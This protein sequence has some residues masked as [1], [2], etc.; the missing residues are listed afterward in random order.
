MASGKIGVDVVGRACRLPGAAGV[1]DL[2]RLLVEER[3]AVSTI[4][5]D[6]WSL[7]AFHHPRRGEP[8]KSYTFRAGVLDRI[9][10]FDPA[11]FGLSKREA[12]Q[13]DPQQRLLLEVTWEAIADSGLRPSDLAGEPVGVFVGVSNLDSVNRRFFDPSSSDPYFMTGNTLSLV[14][15]RLSY[16]F[17][18]R[19]PSFSI[20]TA[21][22][23][24][25]VAL[26]EAVCALESGRIDTAIVAGVNV[27]LSPFPF[28]GFSAA[29][30]LSPEGLCRPF[31]ARGQG[32]VRAEGC[33]SLILQRRDAGRL[34]A[35]RRHARI[36]ASGSNSDGRT[37]GVA[38][39][40][41]E[42]QAALLGEVYARHDLDPNR[43]AFVEAHGTGTRAG[44]PAEARAIGEA[45]GRRR[46]R[47]LPIGSIK[48]NIGHLEPAAGLAGVLKA[49]LAL[50]HDLYPATLHFGEPNPDIAFGALNIEVAG[51][52]VALG[53][54]GTGRIAGVSSFGFGGTNAHVVIADPE[55]APGRQFVSGAALD[56]RPASRDVV[57]ATG[58]HGDEILVI[59]AFDGAALRALARSYAAIWPALAPEARRALAAETVH[60]RDLMP[61]RLV[62]RGRS[63]DEVS[64]RL[65][66]FA[67]DTKGAR[68]PGA[69]SD[70]ALSG[71]ARTAF[72]FNGN[73]AQWAG[74]GRIAL[75][76][77]ARFRASFEAVDRIFAPLAGWSLVEALAAE[78]LEARL[79]RTSIAQP[80]LL[81]VQIATVD[82]LGELGLEPDVVLGHSVGEV[83][84]AYAA[85]CLTLDQAVR[86][87]HARSS[88]QELSRGTGSMAAVQ[89]PAVEV[90]TFLAAGAYAGV[91]VAAV[92]GP[93]S[94]T[95]AGPTAA[96]ET[97]VADLKAKG[98]QAT[99]LK[100]DYPFHCALMDPAAAPLMV[101]LAGL[102]PGAGR[103]PLVSTV[104][105]GEIA[106]TD[107][108]ARYWWRNVR[109][110]VR[111]ADA[112]VA[113]SALGVRVFIEI[114]PHA[115]LR[116][117]VTDGLR[118]NKLESAVL[119]TFTRTDPPGD[120][121]VLAA[122][123]A[124]LA[125]GAL[126]DLE[127]AFGPR[128]VQ[129]AELPSYPWQRTHLQPAW[130]DEAID[131]GL[132]M[133]TPTE[134]AAGRHPHPL[135][136]VQSQNDQ[137]LWIG[138]LDAAA[139]PVLGDHKVHGRIVV[140]GAVFAELALAAGRRWLGA[141]T[142]ELRD[143]D[144]V[145]PLIVDG[146]TLRQVRV[147]ISGDSA[148]VEIASRTRFSG[149]TWQ[150]HAAGR[151][152]LVDGTK[153]IV[154]DD[155]VAAVAGARESAETE[156]DAAQIYA[157]AARLGLAYGP[158]FRL[159]KAVRRNGASALVVDLAPAAGQWG[160]GVALELEPTALD[161]A[162][163]GLLAVAAEH[164][165]SE[166]A[167]VPIRFQS[168]RI[169]TPGASPVRA[170]IAIRKAS[171]RSL[172][173]DITLDDAS[174]RPVVEVL[175]ARFRAV[176]ATAVDIARHM[177]SFS[178]ERVRIQR[179]V[180]EHVAPHPA[181]VAALPGAAG[182]RDGEARLLVEAAARRIALDAALSLA[183]ADGHIG[184]DALVRLATGND[185]VHAYLVS[186][187]D[188]AV[189]ADLAASPERGVW[190]VEPAADDALPALE[191]I[192]TTIMADHPAWGAEVA[193]TA[194]AA[195]AVCEIIEGRF[196]TA[197]APFSTATLDHLATHAP[198]ARGHVET[199]MA[200]VGPRID[201]WPA[202]RALRIV[203]LGA[204]GGE[205][206]RAIAARAVARRGRLVVV[207]ADGPASER[208]RAELDGIDVVEVMAV[209]EFTRQAGALAP[210]DLLVSANGL[211]TLDGVDKVLAAA[212]S[213][214]T[215]DADAVLTHE[216]P[217][218]FHA[219]VL[220]LVPGWLSRSPRPDQPAGRAR[221]AREW[222]ALLARSGFAET[223]PP[224]GAPD[225]SSVSLIL[226][227]AREASGREPQSDVDALSVDTGKV[228]R[229][230]IGP[231]IVL[232]LSGGPG[233]G[234]LL[235]EI[236]RSLA[237]RARAT[238]RGD[239]AEVQTG[240]GAEGDAAG[241]HVRL[242]RLPRDGTAELSAV[243]RV[244]L[245][246][247]ALVVGLGGRSRRLW[248]LL[249]GGARG[250]AGLGLGDPAMAALWA[251][252]RT[253]QNE[254]PAIEL[255]LVDWIAGLPNPLLG[256]RIADAV[257]NPGLETEIVLDEHGAHA[258]RI[259]RHSLESQVPEAP[260][261]ERA[262]QLAV[263]TTGSGLDRLVWRQARRRPPGPGEVEI[264]IAATGLNFRD[265]MWALGLLPEEALED[266]FA[267]PTL[268][269]ECSGRIV[270]IGEG[271]SGLAVGD[272][273]IAMASAAFASHATVAR[274]AVAK[275]PEGVDLVAAASIPVAFLTSYYA[276]HHLAKLE[277]D[278]WVLV[279]GGA[280]GV[281]LSAM[282]IARWRGA[283]VIAT[284]GSPEKRALLMRLGIEH[285]L[286]SRSLAFVDDVRRLTDGEGVDV[287]LNSLAGEA[288]ERSL[289][290]VKPF[291]RFLELGKRDYYANTAIALRPFRRNVS[292]FG[293]DADQLL[294]S[295]PRLSDR[296]LGELM[297]HFAAGTFTPLPYRCFPAD[298]V[299]E[300]CRLMQ[301]SGHIGKIVV[302]PPSAVAG[303][304]AE[305]KRFAAAA[306]G[307]H[308]VIG[309]TSGFGFAT[310]EWLAGR[311]ARHI[312]LASRGGKLAEGLGPRV[313]A[314]E[315]QGV[316][317]R[318]EAC[319]ATRRGD[320]AAL[321][322]G[323]RARG[324]LKGVVHAAMVLDDALIANLD[325]ARIATALAPKIE[326]AR[327]LDALTR[328][329]SLD[330][331]VLY[332]S[333]TTV[334]G[335]PGQAAY[336]AGNAYLEELARARRVSRLPALAVA[337]GAIS[338][339]GVLARQGEK[340]K[341]I[342]LRTGGASLTSAV[343]LEALG[344]LLANGEPG[345]A[346][347]AVVVAPMSWATATKALRTLASPTY[348][349]LRK[350]AAGEGAG[351]AAEMDLVSAIEGLDDAAAQ[352]LIV[353]ALTK[354]IARILRLP[355]E[356]LSPQRPLID[357]GMDSLMSAELLFAARDKLGL[358]I[359]A[360]S[361][362]DS[363]TISDIAA[364]ALARIRG[365][366][367]RTAAIS[368]DLELARQHLDV[369]L[370]FDESTAKA[371]AERIRGESAEIVS[372]GA[373]TKS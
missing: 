288:M 283:R 102:T 113:A 129:R 167:F 299:V 207:A 247:K 265:V 12:E 159:A 56:A 335:N 49:M 17:D 277:A 60:G 359:P 181:P 180:D 192:L 364:K 139:V 250:T 198:R 230:P 308:L 90:A 55:P 148:R 183:D 173:T 85:R 200:A 270:R 190:Q 127:R 199:V 287:V 31:D 324:A 320:L 372:R 235:E 109:E 144:I 187:L 64:A 348:G 141:G 316:E 267:G 257:L 161:A 175:G 357:F 29:A 347:A 295:K 292:Y 260:A 108:D 226:A 155:A 44:D 21:C 334:I 323:I 177:F 208:L 306:D 122:F 132:V 24:A 349:L 269:F 118:G 219:A 166:V 27:L 309:G 268:G 124:A 216:E 2:W 191:D 145:S 48:S 336:V 80:L 13:M 10:E 317:V 83:A 112:I 32:Y 342:A 358:E 130:T 87:I 344:D 92:N 222:R 254:V 296:L 193:L 77:N 62:V 50:E 169:L 367:Q 136:G 362:A 160:A 303:V 170:R 37:V 264:E 101:S 321:I 225:G 345:P 138:H 154:A 30:M 263:N 54:R 53:E 63:P 204:A 213:A 229:L 332:S 71:S 117:Y 285:V 302:L 310:A 211:H 370:D 78:D 106:G 337:W 280:G 328:T 329:D 251:F 86:V 355:A 365:G 353:S 99:L 6:R 107:L 179:G 227:R 128:P 58:D 43:L 51:T 84:A 73:G 266:G 11:P 9:W 94:V 104:T 276:L 363:V 172:L 352:S 20:D 59:S 196:N 312:V 194:R 231:P 1:A 273:V 153:P 82:A 47:P 305:R 184:R 140:P 75:A 282:Q 301:Q 135:L 182:G 4:P 293:I 188:L 70:R 185:A 311:G 366:A 318:L 315:A 279:H 52:A 330:Y 314:L 18:L 361:I 68:I 123:S 253:L 243:T 35:P 91:E 339:T 97:V 350:L 325:A 197:R 233:G 261:T 174:G 133:P 79:T 22:S 223:G 218:G 26:H 126:I 105:G 262:C 98:I 338:D 234:R 151:L 215:E 195:D 241:D 88:A 23:S 239:I 171:E 248:M 232:S 373:G 147:R 210:F 16:V 178:S 331:F 220:G 165:R 149:D 146:D 39:P 93:R 346:G 95:L 252:A 142:I 121:P 259:A 57:P 256:Q 42:A 209:S 326:V 186:L 319:D 201:G 38:L 131:P 25:M 96:V 67:G 157:T 322:E 41:S 66:A 100:L 89:L 275:L 313:A 5:A 304:A 289:E 120:D 212:R 156:I 354:E 125:R 110:P 340:A 300:A 205:L 368:A 369:P 351:V 116:S 74:M 34:A 28:I 258:L 245:D 246:L 242:V 272:S 294:K 202:S 249:P 46:D 8:G 36:V 356:N 206:S 291:G 297:E 286:D 65:E 271:V 217:D 224:A 163:H 3:C 360:M 327:N 341:A 333:V 278:E 162:F 290:L 343:A 152:G 238:R 150:L 203:E 72:V 40:S 214:V 189:D 14:A 119:A 255:R 164:A 221:P 115:I 69:T 137:P 81:A 298:E 143:F 158:A 274:I 45:L 371:V 76:H 111:F 19:G 281:G 237:E 236:E 114:G 33:V 307:I 61:E 168:V 134:L 103:I 176:P 284:A 228:V 15:N 240:E 244:M 7:P